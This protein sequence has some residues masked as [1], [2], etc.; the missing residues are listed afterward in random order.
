MTKI[1][2]E[3]ITTGIAKVE[4]TAMRLVNKK[5]MEAG[6]GK[7]TGGEVEIETTV[8]KRGSDPTPAAK[9]LFGC[10]RSVPTASPPQ[11]RTCSEGV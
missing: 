5:T 3:Q 10:S 4:E 6:G 2:K 7:S 8:D 1:T 11:P 9:N